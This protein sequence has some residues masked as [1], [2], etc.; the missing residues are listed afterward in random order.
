MSE[1]EHP[2][3]WRRGHRLLVL[4][5][6]LLP[7]QSVASPLVVLFPLV[8][9]L[10]AMLWGPL[11][12][13]LSAIGRPLSFGIAGIVV[14]GLLS[15][16]RLVPV[17]LPF[18]LVFA[19]AP[20]F[21]AGLA[22]TT[23]QLS[24]WLGQQLF[25]YS[26]GNSSSLLPS[27]VV[28]LAL[29][30]GGWWSA[31]RLDRF[32]HA[33]KLLQ[34][35]RADLEVVV[36]HQRHRIRIALRPLLRDLFGRID[37]VVADM[38]L[39]R[40][41]PDQPLARTIPHRDVLA[42]ELV[43]A[44]ENSVHKAVDSQAGH[45]LPAR[46]LAIQPAPA[47]LLGLAFA[48]VVVSWH[49]GP[50]TS[51]ATVSALL[52]TAVVL[53]GGLLAAFASKASESVSLH[54]GLTFVGLPVTGLALL[55]VAPEGA[56]G[57]WGWGQGL[58]L[59][60]FLA[61]VVVIGMSVSLS[62]WSQTLRQRAEQLA[63]A[64]TLCEQLAIRHDTLGSTNAR[65]LYSATLG[66]LIFAS[67]DFTNSHGRPDSREAALESMAN[68]IAHELEQKVE[69]HRPLPEEHLR[70]VL[71]M[72]QSI[73][74]LHLTLRSEVFTRFVWSDESAR[75]VQRSLNALLAEVIPLAEGQVTLSLVER[76]RRVVATIDYSGWLPVGGSSLVNSEAGSHLIE[77]PLEVTPVTKT[78]LR[79]LDDALAV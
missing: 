35:L 45:T 16:A 39:E 40:P 11:D 46:R 8:V 32:R 5:S 29:S 49:G 13:E 72:W 62:L 50:W 42:D 6:D 24:T 10:S 15:L 34:S 25:G 63:E 60:G 3:G 67:V 43:Q 4:F 71:G 22:L 56:G 76:D 36:S 65:S 30:F 66:T 54:L 27:L 64:V 31:G 70:L 58:W 17:A 78:P 28:W 79:S 44:I 2:S 73:A 47:M 75:R 41:T 20:L 52:A 38:T 55:V 14:M 33:G 53:A 69:H 26:E 48:S 74:P 61:T 18:A 77:L 23:W 9:L 37:R 68:R 51:Q 21:F 19:I 57:E 7:R 59:A 1:K 12:P